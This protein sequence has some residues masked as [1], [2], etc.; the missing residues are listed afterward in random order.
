MVNVTE[1]L[2]LHLLSACFDNPE[3]NGK[4]HVTTSFPPRLMMPCGKKSITRIT[5]R[6]EKMG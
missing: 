6:P 5:K 4:S 2:V 3:I 1:P